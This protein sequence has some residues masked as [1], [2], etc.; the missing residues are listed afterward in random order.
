MTTPARY[1]AR[2]TTSQRGE[3]AQTASKFAG[4][5][6]SLRIGVC[7]SSAAA[8]APGTV[9]DTIRTTRTGTITPWRHYK[10]KVIPRQDL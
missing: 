2:A 9:R 5:Y 6:W 7:D 3:Q 1:A 8:A 10:K 4:A